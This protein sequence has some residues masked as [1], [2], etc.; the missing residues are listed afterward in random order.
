MNKFKYELEPYKGQ[1]SRH[2][3]PNCN[4]KKSFARYIDNDGNYLGDD[5]GRCNSE[6]SCGYHKK[7]ES[8]EVVVSNFQYVPPITTYLKESD[9]YT[10]QFNDNLYKYL[11]TRFDKDAVQSVFKKYLV[12]STDKKWRNSTVFYQKDKDGRFRTGKIIQYGTNGKRIKEPYSRIYWSHN[13]LDEFVLEQCLF[14][15]HLLDNFDRSKGTIYL[16]ESEKTC[17]I[18]SLFFKN[19]LFI[20]TGGL[21]NLSPLKLSVLRGLGVDAIPDKG[22]YDLWKTKLEPMGI[23][24]NRIMEDCDTSNDGDDVGDLI[25]TNKKPL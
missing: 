5:T 24:V 15:E 21:S 25:L 2:T 11:I 6:S 3:C 18:A 22:G 14:G 12:M 19:D 8:N 1:T 13:F 7:P 9:V 20:A 10:E 4:K 23:S 16:V 17:L